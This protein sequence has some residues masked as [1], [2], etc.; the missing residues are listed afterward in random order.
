MQNPNKNVRSFHRTAFSRQ[1]LL[2]QAVVR[3]AYVFFFDLYWTAASHLASRTEADASS[4][5]FV[6][7]GSVPHPALRVSTESATTDSSGFL[8][9]TGGVKAHSDVEH[10]D[11]SHLAF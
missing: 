6:H 2:K 1:D 7:S 9:R 11:R 4:E 5:V 3:E 8:L 10:D